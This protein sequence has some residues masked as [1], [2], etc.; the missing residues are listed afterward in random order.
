MFQLVH[1]YLL[2][3]YFDR[4]GEKNLTDSGEPVQ[5]EEEPKELTLDE[6]R[7]LRGKRELPQ[8]NI[9]KAGE[10]EDLT[11]WKNM[12]EIKKKKDSVN[13]EEEEVCLVNV[14]VFSHLE[15]IYL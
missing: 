14:Y 11:Q 7:A 1:I 3:N 10:G 15:C 6:Y 2:K 5:V 13:Q 12:Y 9:R 4:D 8:Y